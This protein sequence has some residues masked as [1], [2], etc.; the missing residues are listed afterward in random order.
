M[1][2]SSDLSQLWLIQSWM[3]RSEAIP[4]RVAISICSS[5]VQRMR[6]SGRVRAYLARFFFCWFCEIV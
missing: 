2:A 3:S 4:E 6:A 1:E 5:R